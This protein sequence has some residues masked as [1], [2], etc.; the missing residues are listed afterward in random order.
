MKILFVQ[1]GGTID[2]DYPKQTK[3]YAFEIT[4]PA[5]KQILEKIN[6]SF[7]YEVIS[8]IRKDSMDLTV[9]DKKKIYETCTKADTDKIIITHGTDTMIETAKFLSEVSKKTI[10]IT[11]AFKPEKFSNTDA[12]FNVGAAVG[13]L[14]VLGNGVYIAMNGRIYEYDKVKREKTTGKFIGT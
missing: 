4:E 8:L 10:V 9:K 11:G 7:E 12:D 6:P 5:V 14:N 13:A 2:K 3:G 1:T